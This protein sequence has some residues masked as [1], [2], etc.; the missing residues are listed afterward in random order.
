MSCNCSPPEKTSLWTP[1]PPLR[2][3]TDIL[4]GENIDCFTRR[5]GD[6]TGQ[7]DDARQ[8]LVNHIQNSSIKVVK[9]GDSFAVDEDMTLSQGP[10]TATSW[11][12]SPTTGTL[13]ISADGKLSGTITEGAYKVTVAATDASG[14]IDSR[15]FTVVAAEAKKGESIN[16][17]IPYRS[18]NGQTPHVNSGFGPRMHPIQ[19]IMKMHTGQDWVGGR[20]GEILAAADG[21]VV[22]C[23]MAGGYGNQIRI[24]HLAAD[25]K[26]ICQTTYNHLSQI[27]VTRGQKVG[28]GQVVGKEGSTGASTGPH[29]HFEVRL[30]GTQPVDPAPYLKGDF[31]VQPP[32]Q[33]DGSTPPPKTVSNSTSATPITLSETNARTQSNCPKVIDSGAASVDAST[34]AGT[35]SASFDNKAAT[36]SDCVPTTRPSLAEV[37]TQ[38]DK[39]LD[40]SDLDAEDKKLIRFIAQIESRFDPFA[41]NP[42][43]S[44][45]GLYQMLDKIAVK[46]YG[47]IGIPVTCANRCNPYYATKAMVEFYKRELKTYYDGYKASGESKIANKQIKTT[48]HSSRYPSLSK[49]EFCYGLIHHDGVGNAV[50]GVDCQGVDYYR[51]KVRETGYS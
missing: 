19:K 12:I 45:M 16:L 6:P 25:G 23:G 13:V 31:Q 11:S 33:A 20:Q 41:K 4:P 37:T 40:E 26:I 24:N 28:Q 17:I 3:P 35:P 42:T 43:S 29:L 46:Y 49:G 27:L 8:D 5:A 2:Q 36:T 48:P 39:A 32:V 14:V 15:E 7:Q 1:I 22:F 34:P 9:S 21:E 47:I 18:T 44:A 38:I 10:R 30:G 50:N 51:K